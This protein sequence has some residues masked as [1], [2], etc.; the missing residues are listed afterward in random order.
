MALG[1]FWGSFPQSYYQGKY[2]LH[3]KHHISDWATLGQKFETS[4]WGHFLLCLP[5]FTVAG[6][7]LGIYILGILGLFLGFF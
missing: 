6:P 1:L 7:A 4:Y 2:L 3:R 5:E